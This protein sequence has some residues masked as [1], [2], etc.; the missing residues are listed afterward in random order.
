MGLSLKKTSRRQPVR[1]RH[2]IE[3]RVAEHKKKSKKAAKK[4]VTWKSKVKKDPGI[5]SLFPYKGKLLAEI[6]EKKR[7]DQEAK[8]Q[9][10]A[11]AK[12]AR[13]AE[14]TDGVVDE[15][16]E[17]SEMGM[18]DGSMSMSMSRWRRK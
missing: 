4:D 13:L 1:Q 3:K 18:D 5:P 15:V 8:L 12:A 17:E 11:D 16:Q 9:Q 2:R 7:L 6:E 10:R 14:S